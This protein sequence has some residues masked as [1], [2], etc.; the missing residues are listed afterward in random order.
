MNSYFIQLYSVNVPL[1]FFLFHA[2]IV[3][4]VACGNSSKLP[5]WTFDIFSS[6]FENVPIS[7]IKK[8]KISYSS[9]TST[10]AIQK[11]II[12][13]KPLLLLVGNSVWPD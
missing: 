13:K 9:C 4:D 7:G 1:P 5:V 11:S 2:Q 3:L 6:F 8:K 10:D 12:L